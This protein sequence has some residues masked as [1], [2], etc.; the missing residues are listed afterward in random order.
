MVESHDQRVNRELIE[1]LNEI[2]VALPGIQVL[3]AFLLAVPFSQRFSLVS[4][5]E[6][7]IYFVT[8]LLA[9]IT[10]VLLIAPSSYHRLNFRRRNKDQILFVSNRLMIIG[11]GFLSLA[12]T[13]VVV[14]VT[15]VVYGTVATIVVGVVAFLLMAWF[16]YGLPL[17]H[18][19]AMNAADA[20][21]A[22]D[23]SLAP[24]S[25]Q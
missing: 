25:S 21:D 4:P 14:L 17:W 22:E 23:P 13:G 5:F 18:R 1:L 11:I 9:L 6:R 7:A 19:R 12:L 15:S 2:R 10:T 16:W 3:L 8:V 24:G 20:T